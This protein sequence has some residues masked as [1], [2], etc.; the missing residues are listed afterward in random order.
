MLIGYR[1]RSEDKVLK[2]PKIL[3]NIRNMA[4]KPDVMTNQRRFLET[5]DAQKKMGS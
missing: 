1:K 2:F 5:I 3:N 4:E